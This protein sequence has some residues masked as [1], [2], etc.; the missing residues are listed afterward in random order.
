[1]E[2]CPKGALRFIPE[3]SLGESK[4]MNNILSY[5]HMKEIEFTEKGEQRTIRYAEIGHEEV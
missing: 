5:T 1:M 2:T 4:R 3:Q